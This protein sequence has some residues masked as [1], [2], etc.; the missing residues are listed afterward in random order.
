MGKNKRRTIPAHDSVHNVDLELDSTEEYDF[1]QFCV[2][3]YNLKILDEFQYQPRSFKLFDS[4]NYQT[5]D[6]KTRSLFREHVYS[7][8]FI[9]TFQP[10]KCITLA[11]ELKVPKEKL[12]AKVDVYIDVKG[13]FAKSDGGRSFSINQ[14]WVYDKHKI[15]ICKV[16]PKEFFAICGVPEACRLTAKTKKPRKMF[17]GMKSIAECLIA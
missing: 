9:L 2:E 6:G 10:S 11:R 12:L 15:Y 17:I 3:A 7:P 16:V 8:D 5:I 1:L 4:I 13:T 14:K